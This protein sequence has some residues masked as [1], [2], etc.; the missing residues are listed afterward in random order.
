MGPELR[1][2]CTLTQ[3]KIP[4]PC[5]ELATRQGGFSHPSP[6]ADCHSKSGDTKQ[7]LGGGGLQRGGCY[8]W[9]LVREG[10]P[11][12]PSASHSIFHLSTAEGCS[13][14]LP[15][16]QECRAKDPFP[17]PILRTSSVPAGKAILGAL[18]GVGPFCDAGRCVVLCHWGCCTDGSRA[19]A[20]PVRGVGGGCGSWAVLGSGSRAAKP[21]TV[22]EMGL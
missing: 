19:P 7:P 11:L 13:F 3:R 1:F 16:S 20:A 4:L 12:L 8:R 14:C 6:R 15:P 5:L 18:S 17:H 21:S 22:V 9:Q 10:F 2:D